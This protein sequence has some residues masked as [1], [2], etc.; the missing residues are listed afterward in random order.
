MSEA[1]QANA[2]TERLLGVQNNFSLLLKQ[3]R[4]SA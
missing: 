4:M 3:T 2:P 1:L